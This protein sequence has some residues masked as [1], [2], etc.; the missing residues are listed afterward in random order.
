VKGKDKECLLVG[1]VSITGDSKE[2]E[3]NQANGVPGAQ[4]ASEV[5]KRG[6]PV[7][8]KGGS[9]KKWGRGGYRGSVEV[10]KEEGGRS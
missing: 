8:S 3:R 9:E 6:E 1:V 10:A 5:K 4:G 7:Q 2:K